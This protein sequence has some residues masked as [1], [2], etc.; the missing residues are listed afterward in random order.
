MKFLDNIPNESVEQTQLREDFSKKIGI[1]FSGYFFSTGQAAPQLK[2]GS[3]TDL[4]QIVEGIKL[5]S[6]YLKQ[7]DGYVQFEV[8][9]KMGDHHYILYVGSDIKIINEYNNEEVAKFQSIADAV[10]WIQKNASW[11]EQ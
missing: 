5:L 3:K 9:D 1:G 10:D 7:I 11:E 8:Y 2:I 6:A 4:S